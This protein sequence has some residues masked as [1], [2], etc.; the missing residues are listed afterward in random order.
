MENKNITRIKKIPE[1]FHVLLF[2]R[3]KAMTATGTRERTQGTPDFCV[4]AGI[5][6]TTVCTVPDGDETIS[7]RFVTGVGVR[8]LFAGMADGIIVVPDVPVGVGRLN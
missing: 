8:F 3:M 1:F 4:V 7:V 2:C 5:G 6:D